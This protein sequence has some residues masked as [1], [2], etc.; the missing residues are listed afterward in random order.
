MRVAAYCRVSTDSTD[1]A[2]SFAAQQR[3]FREWISGQPGWTL[4]EIYADEGLSG[5]VANIRPAFQR[6]MED[7]HAGAFSLILSKEVSRFSR[8]LLDTIRYTRELKSIGVE[9]Y[10]LTDG[11]RTM[12]PDAELRLSIMASIAQEESRRTSQRVTWGQVRQMERGVVFGPAPLGYRVKNG[13][14]YIVEKEAQLVRHMFELYALEQKSCREIAATLSR[15]EGRCWRAGTV[16]KI[17]RNEKYVGDLTQR[18]SYTPDYLTHTKRRNRG[19]VPLISLENHHEA[20]VSRE[21]WE[22][23][24]QRLGSA[25]KNGEAVSRRYAFS[26]KIR[27][28][29]C[30]A[31]FTAKKNNDYRYWRCRCG[32]GRMLRDEDAYSML[33]SALEH[34]QTE[35]FSAAA[36]D[37]DAMKRQ[38]ERLRA[39]ER[40]MQDCYFDGELS[41]EE[42]KKLHHTLCRQIAALEAELTASQPAAMTVMALW[43][44]ES[45]KRLMAQNCLERI[46]VFK[47]RPLELRLNGLPTVFYYERD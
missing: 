35:P 8:N 15:E 10:F 40:R 34:L 23:T 25:R 16:Q 19:E 31:Y 26:G 1:Q 2:N 21:L 32:I 29:E 43:D 27:C 12:D 18:K 37:T 38:L 5:T 39:R 13:E 3:Y 30:G 33:Q 9:V 22:A 41:A 17:L 36:E 14:L 7:A 11:I 6:M 20:I 24:Q 28:G 44:S 4:A 42:Y 47:D 45:G 46:T